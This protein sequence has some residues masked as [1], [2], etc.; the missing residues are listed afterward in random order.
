[1]PEVS[2]VEQD[3]VRKRKKVRWIWL[4]SDPTSA[5]NP[6]P[7]VHNLLRPDQ[8][9]YLNETG[10][11]ASIL[12]INLLSDMEKCSMQDPAVDPVQ[13]LAVNGNDNKV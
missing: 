7:H 11:S 12:S 1:M 4:T 6:Q 5:I 9:L 10:A 2:S 8:P 13:V 3:S